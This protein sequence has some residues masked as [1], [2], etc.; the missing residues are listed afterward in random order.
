MRK[1]AAMLEHA[2]EHDWHPECSGSTAY[3][4]HLFADALAAIEVLPAL[5]V[6]VPYEHIA[7]VPRLRRRAT[8]C[9]AT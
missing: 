7:A 2:A 6:S 8:D 1:A 5:G 4:Q 9:D 3:E